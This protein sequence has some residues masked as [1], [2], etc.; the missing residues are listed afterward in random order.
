MRAR[1]GPVEGRAILKRVAIILAGA[2]L[3]AGCEWK[4]W[5]KK[6]SDPVILP[7]EEVAT[8]A[9]APVE[10]EPVRPAP[11]EPSAV[12]PGPL[13]AGPTEPV[14]VPVA[15]ARPER[16]P[17]PVSPPLP[18]PEPVSPAPRRVRPT[19]VATTSPSHHVVRG[20][21]VVEAAMVQVNNE[22]ITLRDVLHPIR[23]QLQAAPQGT[24]LPDFRRKAAE[25]VRGQLR[26]QIEQ[27]LLL[28]E[29]EDRITEAERAGIE[30]EIDRRYRR[31]LAEMNGSRTR[32]AERLRREGTDIETWKRDQ[33]RALTVQAFLQRRI[34]S[35]IYVTRRM[36][37]EYY[38]AHQADFR[39][40]GRVQMQMVS[41]P[42]SAYLPSERKATEEEH[43]MARKLARRQIERAAAALAAGADLGATAQKYGKGPM[44]SSGGIWPS[45]EVGSF[46][47]AHVEQVAYRQDVGETSQVVETALGFYI[48]K[49]LACVPGRQVPFEQVQ[50]RIAEHLRRRQYDK[51]TAVY[52]EDLRDRATIVLADGFEKLAV[53]AAVRRYYHE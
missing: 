17:E 18:A 27:T 42:L 31:A 28:A 51:H 32:L 9:P 1:A 45:M 46:R 40:A 25:L 30:K 23:E 47:D 14:G 4:P 29:A 22:F 10:P 5:W 52:L 26:R 36:M 15:P 33:R 7:D 11:V 38:R 39:T 50:S 49:T 3:L 34:F 48:V 24:S 53:D 6:E 8:T 2:M 19:P 12:R 37:M 21:E 44:A 16:P 20:S 35:K 43:A 41:V 13:A